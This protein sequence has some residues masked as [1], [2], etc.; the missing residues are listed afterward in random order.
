MRNLNG[1]SNTE[2]KARTLRFQVGEGC[3]K[4]KL[5]ESNYMTVCTVFSPATTVTT[6][7]YID[8]L[9]KKILSKKY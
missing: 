6:K 2:E 4:Q 7:E 5:N 9:H 1:K 3:W 8:K